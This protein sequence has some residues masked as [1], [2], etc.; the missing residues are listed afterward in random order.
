MKD[1]YAFDTAAAH[2][3]RKKTAKFR[4]YATAVLVLLRQCTS[5]TD[6]DDAAVEARLTS[7]FRLE[8]APILFRVGPQNVDV[9]IR[10]PREEKPCP[11][12]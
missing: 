11:L 4:R 1:P 10:P 2:G 9:Q 6:L 5:D 12:K 3:L 8:Y 7:G